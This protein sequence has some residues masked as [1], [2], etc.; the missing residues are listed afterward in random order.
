MS[1]RTSPVRLTAVV[2]G[3]VI[4]VA[5]V[6][7]VVAVTGGADEDSRLDELANDPILVD[8]PVTAEVRQSATVN[9][10][11]EEAF[12]VR[13]EFHTAGA[14]WSV[15][16]GLDATAAAWANSLV[17]DD[18]WQDVVAVCRVNADGLR[19]IG[20]GARRSANGYTVS[21]SIELVPADADT[22]RVSVT[23][24]VPVDGD[25]EPTTAAPPDLA[26]LE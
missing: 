7:A 23:L 9:P 25:G 15:P 26:C 5:V 14:R 6:V 12:G 17:D 2:V 21:A 8:T 4:A 1:E 20:L 22:T 16:L 24:F 13:E 11:R 3:A 18:V 19:Q 10:A